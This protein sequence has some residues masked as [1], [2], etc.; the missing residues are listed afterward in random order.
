MK[1]K[2]DGKDIEVKSSQAQ[3][4]STFD[5]LPYGC[6][7][8]LYRLDLTKENG[9]AAYL[10]MPQHLGTPRDYKDVACTMLRGLIPRGVG[11]GEGGRGRTGEDVDGGSVV[12][13][14]VV[15]VARVAAK[16]EKAAAAMRAAARAVASSSGSGNG[17]GNGGGGAR[18]PRHGR[19]ACNDGRS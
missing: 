5:R 8:F 11:G 19:S 2:P 6:L 10:S 3:V 17:G 14:T 12:E 1:H 9:A 7:L 18:R 15:A 13:V 4:R 16:A